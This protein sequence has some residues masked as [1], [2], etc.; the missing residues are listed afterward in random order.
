[1]VNFS[2]VIMSGNDNDLRMVVQKL[3]NINMIV[4]K[5]NNKRGASTAFCTQMI[6][7]TVTKEVSSYVSSTNVNIQ[8]SNFGASASR[9]LIHP[10]LV[11]NSYGVGISVTPDQ[12]SSSVLSLQCKANDT[13]SIEAFAYPDVSEAPFD[14]LSDGQIKCTKARILQ[15]KT[16]E[17]SSKI[18]CMVYQQS[19]L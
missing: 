12:Y 13:Y 11:T 17:N 1:M 15:S 14:V 5:G 8:N 9:N 4:V 7:D 10:V 18:Y 16:G 3:N 2:L 19:C 6:E